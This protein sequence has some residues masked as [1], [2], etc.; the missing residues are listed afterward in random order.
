MRRKP[1]TRRGQ[2]KIPDIFGDSTPTTNPMKKLKTGSKIRVV[3]N[4]N[5]H[6]YTVGAVYTVSTI[7]SNDNTLKATD[8]SGTTGN[9]IRMSDVTMIGNVGWEFI[10][11]V[12]P[13]DVTQFLGAFDGIDQVELT[14]EV[15]DAILLSLPD[16]HDRILKEALKP[17]GVPSGVPTDSDSDP[18]D[19]FNP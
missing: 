3:S 13:S 2:R 11:K 12:L 9:W 14:G 5:D 10:K 19:I 7:D 8:A 1:N 6:N 18:D 15:K 17:K 16:L 4:S